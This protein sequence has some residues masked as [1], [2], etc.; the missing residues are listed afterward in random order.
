MVSDGLRVNILHLG[1]SYRVRMSK[2][3]M[4]D[5]FDKVGYDGLTSLNKTI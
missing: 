4:V 5:L 1:L 3:L 2:V